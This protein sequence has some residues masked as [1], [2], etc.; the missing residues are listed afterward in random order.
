[1]KK[2][3]FY[4]ALTFILAFNACNKQTEIP[5]VSQGLTL[6]DITVSF[7]NTNTK[8][9]NAD[10]ISLTDLNKVKK[11]VS[12]AVDCGFN[13][14]EFT[15]LSATILKSAKGDFM[16]STVIKLPNG[17][18]TSFLTRLR[19][20]ENRLFI[21]YAFTEDLAEL[22]PAGDEPT[23]TCFNC[24]G[25]NCC[26]INYY[27]STGLVKCVCEGGANSQCVLRTWTC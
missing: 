7:L 12:K 25:G 26:T 1:M 10:A 22:P 6:D 21:R 9:S 18:Q 16:L 11:A 13:T 20:H 4:F 3:L 23:D 15:V 5:K 27:P 8:Q 2:N 17:E 19:L 14:K 24:R